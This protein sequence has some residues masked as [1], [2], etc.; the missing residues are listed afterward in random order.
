MFVTLALCL[1]LGFADAE[2]IAGKVVGV[3]DGDTV[4]VLDAAKVQHK[5]RLTGIDAP[6]KA[7]PFGQRSKQ[8]LSN[9]VFAKQVVVEAGKSDRYGRTVG[10]VVVGGIDANLEQVRAGYAWHYKK[11]EREQ[12]IEDRVAYAA[13]ESSARAA[14]AGLWR[15]AV[16]M[17]PWDWRSCRRKQAGTEAMD[18]GAFRR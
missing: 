13:A 18:C 15:D 4:T 9:L 8:N 17:P 10:K 5:I 2:T 3:A 7:Q 6:E 12:S 14:R 16:Q 11:Y 1:S